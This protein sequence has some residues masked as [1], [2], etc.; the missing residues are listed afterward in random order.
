MSETTTGSIRE[1]MDAA[2]DHDPIELR[3]IAEG[4]LARVEKAEDELRIRMERDVSADWGG[5]RSRP[6]PAV[7]GPGIVEM[8]LRGAD[9]DV[10]RILD[11]LRAGGA[12][13]RRRDTCGT[14]TGNRAGYRYYSAEVPRDADE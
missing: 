3:E 8:S 6:K 1:Q 10:E 13:V 9:E 14:R 4:L 5:H 7:L 12:V 11:A 2:L